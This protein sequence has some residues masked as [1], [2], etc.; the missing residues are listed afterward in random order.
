MAKASNV[1]S[2]TKAAAPSG[3]P[4]GYFY[5]KNPDSSTIGA[6]D[7]SDPYSG[8]PY[9]AYRTPG[10]SSTT[11]DPTRVA[12][13]FDPRVAA[14]RPQ[15][16]F[17]NERMPSSASAPIKSAWGGDS[18]EELDH[19]QPLEL[20]GSNN[21]KNLQLEPHLPGSN[22]TATDPLENSLAQDVASG[23]KSLF[24]AQTEMA[25]AKK[26]TAPYV[27][28]PAHHANILDYIK[29][30]F[31]KLPSELAGIHNPFS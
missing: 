12:T 14:P 25:A 31:D 26:V 17:H 9:F 18:S 10:A 2:V 24:E 23:K 29:G 1:P 15:S 20:E 28:T 3:A 22:N 21:E 19:I 27:G 4:S 8:T 6:S 5:A 16:T 7:Q 11:T 30:A 13:T